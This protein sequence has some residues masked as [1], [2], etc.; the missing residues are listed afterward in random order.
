MQF[1]TTANYV[2]NFSKLESNVDTLYIS[3]VYFL[4]LNAKSVQLA[5]KE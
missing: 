4:W 1:Q 5:K 3:D 2:S